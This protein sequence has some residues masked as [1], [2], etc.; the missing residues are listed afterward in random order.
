MSLTTIPTVSEGSLG[1]L[2][3]DRAPVPNLIEYVTAEEVNVAKTALAAV[4]AAVGLGDGSS[5][6]SIEARLAAALSAPG[7]SFAELEHFLAV[8]PASSAAFVSQVS[9]GG[10]LQLASWIALDAAGITQPTGWLQLLAD[11]N[12]TSAGVLTQ[13]AHFRP[14]LD[15]LELEARLYSDAADE[16]SGKF[17]AGL[18]GFSSYIRASNV[19][20]FWELEGL[21]ATGGNSDASSNGAVAVSGV[22]VVNLAR[23]GG[24]WRLLVDGVEAATSGDLS[25]D[26]VPVAGDELGAGADNVWTAGTGATCWLDYLRI[27]HGAG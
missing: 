15:G 24:V 27:A 19:S 12:G 11:G 2:K 18:A 7:Q 20:G 22:Q 14:D 8:P 6:G 9:G 1:P 13:Q 17:W 16:G 26:A 25:S 10:S 21:S 3:Q 5:A 23:S 4:C